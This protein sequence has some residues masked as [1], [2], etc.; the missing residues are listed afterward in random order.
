MIRLWHTIS[1]IWSK[2]EQRFRKVQ[3]VTQ[4]QPAHKRRGRDLHSRLPHC[5][6]CSPAW[7]PPALRALSL[8]ATLISSEV[9]FWASV[10]PRKPSSTGEEGRRRAMFNLMLFSHSC[11]VPVPVHGVF[12]GQCSLTGRKCSDKW[13]WPSSVSFLGFHHWD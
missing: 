2:R 6:C 9:T 10:H 4:G 11:K 7:S 3:F 12:R 13:K 5:R 1:P 8:A